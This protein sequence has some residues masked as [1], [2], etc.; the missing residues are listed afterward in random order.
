MVMRIFAAA[1]GMVPVETAPPEDARERRL[2][3]LREESAHMTEYQVMALQSVCAGK[4]VAILGPAGT[5]KTFIIGII[6]KMACD[7]HARMNLVVTATTGLAASCIDGVTLHAAMGFSSV[8]IESSANVAQQLSRT[9][10]RR[11]AAMKAA[12]VLIVDEISMIGADYMR[13]ASDVLCHIRRDSNPFGGMQV[14]LLGDLLQLVMREDASESHWWESMGFETVRLRGSIRQASDAAF[15]SVLDKIR[16]GRFS[17]PAVARHMGE[18]RMDLVLSRPVAQPVQWESAL[19]LFSTNAQAHAYNMDHV[20]RMERRII[21]FSPKMRVF[22][23]VPGGAAKAHVFSAL[24]HLEGHAGCARVRSRDCSCVVSSRLAG[25]MD[26]MLLRTLYSAASSILVEHFYAEKTHFC[27]GARVMCIRNVSVENGLSNGATGTVVGW[28]GERDPVVQTAERPLDVE[29][30]WGGQPAAVESNMCESTKG[31]AFS[32]LYYSKSDPEAAEERVVP[33]VRMDATGRA[34]AFMPFSVTRDCAQASVEISYV[35]L[36]LAHALTVHKAQGLTLP[37]VVVHNTVDMWMPG[38][39]YV[40]I[41]RVPS[42]DRLLLTEAWQP[43]N[44]SVSSR[45]CKLDSME[46][47]VS[48]PDV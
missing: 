48:I 39:L 21:E 40:A 2:R 1:R 43:S 12:N 47:T 8:G 6:R 32:K 36:T 19:H 17:D 10:Q 24:R 41:S 25:I 26:D 42:L 13:F 7:S 22:E 31:A 30:E 5:G 16:V 27:V 18:R 29:Q 46:T 34:V 11:C 20:R 37:A 44:H 33:V 9:N 28:C 35:P 15:A 45:A 14:V 23:R 4:N 38:Q 3:I